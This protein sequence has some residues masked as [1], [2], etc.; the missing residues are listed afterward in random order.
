MLKRETVQLYNALNYIRD[1]RDVKASSIFNFA[2]AYNRKTLD[3][4]MDSL[5]EMRK[6]TGQVAEY[7]KKLSD[8]VSQIRKALPREEREEA[9]TKFESSLKEAYPHIDEELRKIEE[10]Y[11]QLLTTEWE[12]TL[13]KVDA[14]AIPDNLPGF[15][16]DALTP[17]MI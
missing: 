11:A 16:Y 8:Y 17:L 3:P 5:N 9:Y 13:V 7:K 1:S 12:V 15:V 6:G 2:S 14:L 4:L 10:D